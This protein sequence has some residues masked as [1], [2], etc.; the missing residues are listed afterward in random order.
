MS[1]LPVPSAA[2]DERTRRVAS[3]LANARGGRNGAPA[4]ANVLELLQSSP[5]LR[6]LYDE[7][8]EDARSAIRIADET[9]GAA[10]LRQALEESVKLQSHY[11]ELQN[12]YDGG[13]RRS[14][15][16]AQEW[17]DR[18]AELRAKATPR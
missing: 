9:S 11:A 3:A 1:G 6:K 5:G 2:L 4:V 10:E 7:V 15:A 17:L 8:M 14:F 12:I 16:S 13:T 18:L